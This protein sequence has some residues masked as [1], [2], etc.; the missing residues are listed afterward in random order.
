VFGLSKFYAGAATAVI[1]MGIAI[2]AS[3]LIATSV[4]HQYHKTLSLAVKLY[5]GFA[6]A[7]SMI[8]TSAGI[9]G[10]L[11][12][13]YQETA[14]KMNIEDQVISAEQNRLIVFEQEVKNLKSEREMLNDNISKANTNILKL[15][16][17][18]SNNVVQYTNADGNVITTQ[19]SSTRKILKEQLKEQS[20]Y[21]DT[22]IVKRDKL[23]ETTK[24]A[25]DSINA[26]NIRILQ[27]KT[28]SDIAGEI[29]PLKYLSE[30]TGAP[31]NRVVNW[32]TI[33]LIIIF[34]PLAVAL[35]IVLNNIMKPIPHPAENVSKPDDEQEVE[36]K[37]ERVKAP[38]PPAPLKEDIYKEE[39]KKEKPKRRNAYWT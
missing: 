4:L 29:G 5:L 12:S 21:R 22:L 14:F 19:S 9:Y 3:K 20:D 26:V 30:L 32:F 18:L 39:K 11:I 17:G 31:M 37:A 27:L 2:E 7:V 6:I 16:E 23:S 13:A 8:I 28:N 35:V 10:F 33:L 24:I 34:D 25:N 36:S 38:T 1:I 15:S